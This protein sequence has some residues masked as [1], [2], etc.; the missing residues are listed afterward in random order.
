VSYFRAP[1][2]SVTLIAADKSVSSER[3]CQLHRS[4]DIPFG[5]VID[6]VDPS[7]VGNLK[8]SLPIDEVPSNMQK[9]LA[10][11]YRHTCR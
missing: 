2:W 7:D 11:T 4:L 5:Q 9:S 3:K 10:S 6:T 1:G 8:S